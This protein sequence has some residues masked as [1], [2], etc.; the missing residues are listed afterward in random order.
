MSRPI[1]ARSVGA[2]FPEARNS[3]PS[4]STCRPIGRPALLCGPPDLTPGRGRM[5]TLTAAAATRL[6]FCLVFKK[7]NHSCAKLS[8]GAR[9]LGGVITSRSRRFTW[10]ALQDPE[11]RARSPRTV[12]TLGA[13]NDRAARVRWRAPAGIEKVASRASRSPRPRRQTGLTSMHCK[14]ESSPPTAA[15]RPAPDTRP[16]PAS[17][18][19]AGPRIDVTTAALLNRPFTRWASTASTVLSL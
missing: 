19:P 5:N 9:V 10:G 15:P 13:W 6:P 17:E 16:S 7:A 4:Y 3:E 12:A 18:N 1:A 14:I 8:P 2:S 11:P